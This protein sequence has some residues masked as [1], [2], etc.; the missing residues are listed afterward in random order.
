MPNQSRS[1]TGEEMTLIGAA[2]YIAQKV[3]F[4]LYGI[5]SHLSPDHKAKAHRAFKDLTPE[6][7]LRGDQEKLKATFGLLAR[8]FGPAFFIDTPG[9]TKFYQDRNLIA[10]NYFRFFCANI[11]GAQTP[12]DPIKFLS[13]F[14]IRGEHWLAVMKGLT[15]VLMEGA[16]AREGRL[17]ELT[18]SEQDKENIE[19]YVE[20]LAE[21]MGVPRS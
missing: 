18:F 7:F 2:I 21:R 11:Q 13:D 9:L 4:A 3:E 16:A 20:T 8:E 14:I 6:A 19:K 17:D 10:H 15:S 12:D 5:G 1:I